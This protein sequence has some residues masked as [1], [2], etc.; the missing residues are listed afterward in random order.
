M[1][2]RNVAV[3]KK[4]SLMRIPERS[5]NTKRLLK[6]VAIKRK[7]SKMRTIVVTIR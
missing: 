6:S 2:K 1:E 7:V 3:K 5:P 4:H